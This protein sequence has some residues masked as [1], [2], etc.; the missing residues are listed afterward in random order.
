MKLLYTEE[1]LK[2]IKSEI[3]DVLLKY[4]DEDTRSLSIVS[5]D[6]KKDIE[7]NLLGLLQIILQKS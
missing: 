4:A 2:C 7:D 5:P 1:Q 6:P 3:A